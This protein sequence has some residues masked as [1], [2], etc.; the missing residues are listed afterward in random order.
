MAGKSAYRRWLDDQ[1]E[2]VFDLTIN[3]GWGYSRVAD[4]SGLSVST[5]YYLFSNVTQEPR[6]S[7]LWKLG[8][9]VG[10]DVRLAKKQ[11]VKLRK[12]G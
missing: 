10:M 9:A 11:L 1:I 8:R 6:L 4:E 5:V 12:A 2:I 7:T 3:K